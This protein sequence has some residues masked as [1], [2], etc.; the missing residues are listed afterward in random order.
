M[1]ENTLP[2]SFFND[3]KPKLGFVIDSDVLFTFKL[4][5]PNNFSLYL[6]QVFPLLSENSLNLDI[7]VD[8]NKFYYSEYPNTKTGYKKGLYERLFHL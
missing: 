5:T 2:K 8:E 6:H 7:F 4:I 1:N 3:K